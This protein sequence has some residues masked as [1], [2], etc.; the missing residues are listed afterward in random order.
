MN[1]THCDS[2]SFILLGTLGQTTHLRCRCCGTNIQTT[3][4]IDFDGDDGEAY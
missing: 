1:C 3:E 2:N 4:A